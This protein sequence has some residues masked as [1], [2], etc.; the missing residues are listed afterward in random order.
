[1]KNQVPLGFAGAVAAILAAMVAVRYGASAGRPPYP[2]VVPPPLND[3]WAIGSLE[4]SG[5]SRLDRSYI[6]RYTE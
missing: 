5:D 3:G 2:Y 1:M 4:E 6:P